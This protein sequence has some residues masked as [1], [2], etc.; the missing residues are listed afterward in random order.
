MLKILQYAIVSIMA[1]MI[2]NVSYG[3][4]NGE[5]PNPSSVWFTTQPPASLSDVSSATLTSVTTGLRMGKTY[6]FNLYV[7]FISTGVVKFYI[8]DSSGTAN[9]CTP[10]VDCTTAIMKIWTTSF[11]TCVDYNLNS[12]SSL[13][14]GPFAGISSASNWLLVLIGCSDADTCEGKVRTTDTY[15]F[16]VST[17]GICKGNFPIGNSWPGQAIRVKAPIYFVLSNQQPS[18]VDL[19]DIR[20][21]FT[22]GISV[23]GTDTETPSRK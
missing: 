22:V 2:S 7:D 13:L 5:D 16:A 18:G 17:D 10:D 21:D 14:F 1:L 6:Y 15:S 11:M 8:L 23:T 12:A 9:E 3:S 20:E 4:W 19:S